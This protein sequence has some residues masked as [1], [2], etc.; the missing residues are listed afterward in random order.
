MNRRLRLL[1][2][3]TVLVVFFGLV[4]SGRSQMIESRNYVIHCVIDPKQ[5]DYAERLFKTRLVQQDPEATL[6]GCQNLTRVDLEGA[7]DFA[8]GA[9]CA[10]RIGNNLFSALL[11][12]DSRYGRL[13]CAK[14][15]ATKRDDVIRYI[16]A[17]CIPAGNR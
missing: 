2:V 8:L 9:A 6:L 14:S 15:N 11:C 7:R 10:V 1:H 4:S 3:L 17:N 12:E 16:E 5:I 13:L